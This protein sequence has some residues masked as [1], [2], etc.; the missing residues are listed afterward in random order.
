MTGDSPCGMQYQ[1]DTVLPPFEITV[2]DSFG[3]PVQGGLLERVPFDVKAS[4]VGSGTYPSAGFLQLP[5]NTQ[6]GQVSFHPFDFCALSGST[7]S[8]SVQAVNDSSRAFHR[9]DIQPIT[10][11]S[12][13][14]A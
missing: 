13:S 14:F 5:M 12:F 7:V 6:T 1:L 8:L 10:S 11:C 9:F 2:E 4:Y 3:T